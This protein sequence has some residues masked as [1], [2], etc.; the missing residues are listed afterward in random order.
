MK[1]WDNT[2]RVTPFSTEKSYGN[3]VSCLCLSI[4]IVFMAH[5]LFTYSLV[6]GHLG[7]FYLLVIVNS[8]AMNMVCK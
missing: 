1:E 6:H 8:A 3:L 2:C 5:I 4:S 7:C